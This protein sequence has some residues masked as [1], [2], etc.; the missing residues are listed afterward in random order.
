VPVAGPANAPRPVFG[1]RPGSR[2]VGR[3]WRDVFGMGLA[4]HGPA[5]PGAAAGR[6]GSRRFDE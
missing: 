3:G 2:L 6:A 4:I 5:E 1:P